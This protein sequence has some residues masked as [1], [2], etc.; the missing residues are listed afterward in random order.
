[1]SFGYIPH[2]TAWKDIILKVFGHPSLIRR[3]Q[4]PVLMRMLEPKKGELILDAGCGGGFL[5]YEIA[6]RCNISVG[7]DLNLNSGYPF[8]M[9]KLSNLIYIKGDVERLPFA[10]DKFDKIVLS[11]VLQMGED[12]VLVVEESRRVPR[13]QGIVVLSIPLRYIYFSTLNNHK[14]QIRKKF[15]ASGEWHYSAEKV[16]N[17]LESK[18]FEILE[19]EHSP[20]ELGSLIYE[21]LLFCGIVLDFP[22][23]IPSCLHCSIP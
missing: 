15:G 8:A 10:S 23:S 20:K 4:A 11:S 3:I 18:G 7:I 5:S 14:P 16:I 19:T 2:K 13:K 17:L 22:L 21:I 12:E 1:M 6:K 9:S